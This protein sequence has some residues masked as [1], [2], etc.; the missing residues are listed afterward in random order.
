MDSEETIPANDG[1]MVVLHVKT[2]G[3]EGVTEH[4]VAGISALDLLKQN[5]DVELRGT[6]RLS[7]IICIDE[8]CA[9]GGYFWGFYVNEKPG[10]DPSR[11]I[12]KRGDT[13]EFILTGELEK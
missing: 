10:T 11:Y 6:E 4:D 13:L 12:V 7:E 3:S 5:H 9:S 2:I 1:S 8:V